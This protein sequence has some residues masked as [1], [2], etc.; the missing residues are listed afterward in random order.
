MKRE[1]TQDRIGTIC[2][3]FI[4]VVGIHL[5]ELTPCCRHVWCARFVTV[6]I[7][8]AILVLIIVVV[9][10]E[11]SSYHCRIK[12]IIKWYCHRRTFVILSNNYTSVVK[13][14]IRNDRTEYFPSKFLGVVFVGSFLCDLIDVFQRVTIAIIFNNRIFISST[15]YS[16]VALLRPYTATF[17]IGSVTRQVFPRSCTINSCFISFLVAFLLPLSESLGLFLVV[18][19][20][21]FSL[22]LVSF[23]NFLISHSFTDYIIVF[24]FVVIAFTTKA[25]REVLVI[26]ILF[27]V[28]IRRRRIF[29]FSSRGLRPRITNPTFDFTTLR[30][31]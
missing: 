2:F 3:V 21:S 16:I 14:S 11:Q 15:V 8:T 26:V 22:S 20:F 23:I 28:I 7:V 10:I 17:G 5:F 31:V 19:L 13:H 27:I 9:V 12:R 1:S 25:I 24:I 6:V 4:S 30:E 18:S 29:V